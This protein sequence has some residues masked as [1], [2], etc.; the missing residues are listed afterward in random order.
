MIGK[1]MTPYCSVFYIPLF[2]E[3]KGEPFMECTKCRGKFH[4]D[5]QEI[6]HHLANRE[7]ELNAE[8][9]K[10]Q[11]SFAANPSDIET[12]CELV[13]LLVAADRENEGLQL[14]E[15]LAQT[16]A[17]NANVHVMLARVYMHQ[18]NMDRMFQAFQRAIAINPTHA[19]AHYYSAVA[20]LNADPPKLDEALSIAKQARDYGHPDARE[21]IEAIEQAKASG[22]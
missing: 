13:E 18:E 17:D 12:G 9:E 2:P 19:G 15:Q 21:L 1:A 22:L 10:K 7:A 16:H 3:G 20:M 4:G 8:I 5:V 6:R 11:Q 14:A